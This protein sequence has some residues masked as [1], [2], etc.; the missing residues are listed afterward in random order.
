MK[1]PSRD[2]GAAVQRAA[3]RR[4]G[5]LLFAFALV[6]RLLFWQATPDSAGAYSAYYKGDAATWL[7]Y[8]EALQ[9]DRPFELG[10]PLRPPGAAYLIALLWNGTNAGVG[11]LRL[12]WC[13]MGAAT[14][15]LIYGA[16]LR[17][18][19][20]AAALVTGFLCACSTGLMMLS[21]S[22]DN[23]T[24]YLLL[25]AGC[26]Y[27]WQPVRQR[28]GGHLLVAWSALHAMA[29]LV[30]VEHALF[31]AIVTVHLAVAW[32]LEKGGWRRSLGRTLGALSCFA[33]VLL[34]WQ[35]HASSTIRR[36]NTVP[37]TL[38]AATENAHQQLEQALGHLSWLPDA[39]AERERLPAFCRRT[40]ANFVAATVATRG[41][42]E[43][44]GEDFDLLA[45]AF[46]TRPEPVGERPFLVL[47]GGLNFYLANNAGAPGGFGR[48]PLEQPPLLAGGA[49]SYPR[50]LVQGLPPPQLNFTYPP[51]LEIVNRGYLL[52]LEW[53][54]SHP[55]DFMKLAVE[56]LRIFW[57]GAA[58]GAGGYNLPLGL[59]GARRA[60]DLVVPEGGV[61]VVWRFGALGLCALGLLAGRR[62]EALFPWLWFLASKVAVTVAFFGYARHGATVIPVLALLAALA[63]E[64]WIPGVTGLL[65][66]RDGRWLR[67]CAAAMLLL[68]A[69]EGARWFD[70]PTV[71]LDG[72]A[73]SAA[74]PFPVDEYRDRRLRV[75]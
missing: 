17:S 18:F 34:P 13:L 27:L 44:R 47:Y 28:S 54:R 48:V 7:A 50:M 30:R 4:A 66:E 41:R 31:F 19:S 9:Q 12:L 33:L 75:E 15:L 43:V 68:V 26:L 11:W 10:L 40:A 37:E 25:V 23:E 1:R 65:R 49:S 53:I 29:C 60:V 59:S 64:R 70:G 14:V 51:H 69:V 63:A 21:T 2:A 39:D 46:G 58:L 24:P 38:N 74:D 67:P 61:S 6:L 36:F 5:L 35:L 22:L 16:V 62:H 3:R 8:A 72:E 20:F 55:G 73:V 71:T 56:K 42:L 57:Q 45:D 52:G 32:T